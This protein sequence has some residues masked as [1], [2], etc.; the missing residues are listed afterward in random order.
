MN[1]VAGPECVVHWDMLAAARCV[2][3]WQEGFEEEVVLPLARMVYG[4]VGQSYVALARPEGATL[5]GKL[6]NVLKFTVKEIDPTTGVHVLILGLHVFKDQSGSAVPA[7]ALVI[8]ALHFDA[9][10]V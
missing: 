8:I 2:G 6:T 3:L 1:S 5:V 9:S 7:P 4:E 10:T